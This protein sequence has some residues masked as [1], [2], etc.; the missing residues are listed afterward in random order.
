M[1]MSELNTYSNPMIPKVMVNPLIILNMGA[2]MIY[3]LQQRL[4]AQKIAPDKASRVLSDTVSALFDVTMIDTIFKP[5]KTYESCTV[6][7][8]FHQI[9]H[10]S[11]MRLNDQSM[12][13]LYDLML[14]GLK[15]QLIRSRDCYELIESTLN[16]IDN[17]YN[18]IHDRCC[19]NSKNSDH[20]NLL[21]MIHGVRERIIRTYFVLI[22][23]SK[24]LVIRKYLF[25]WLQDR[26]IKVSILL[27]KNMQS[28][29]GHIITETK[30]ILPKYTD[31]PGK[32]CRITLQN[33]K[34]NTV[35]LNQNTLILSN[36]KCCNT[37]H[38]KYTFQ[39]NKL[40]TNIGENL[41][42]SNTS[43]N[44]SNKNEKVEIPFSPSR[45]NSQNRFAISNAVKNQLNDLSCII[46]E[47]HTEKQRKISNPQDIIKLDLFD[48]EMEESKDGDAINHN[49]HAVRF[50]RKTSTL[51]DALDA[52]D[53]GDDDGNDIQ[54]EDTNEEEDLFDLL[55]DDANDVLL[56]D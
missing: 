49:K 38:I 6:R 18:I 43:K 34:E 35:K 2:E 52:L 47:P 24:L 26:R 46:N 12:D 44:N 56:V 54:S 13:K 39:F 51:K 28:L 48:V 17:I 5:L 11:I 25:Q 4:K 14:M 10:S 20:D 31:I 27:Q 3:I 1:N 21:S 9:T 16:H 19:K 8:L 36:S 37:N 50:G 40:H 29:D 53:L 42:H 22:S 32:Q 41:Y 23:S 55:N 30:G 15:V 7:E 45:Q 33:V